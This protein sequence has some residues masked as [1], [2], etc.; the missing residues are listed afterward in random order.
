MQERVLFFARQAI[1]ICFLL[2][3]GFL[4]LLFNPGALFQGASAIIFPL[5]YELFEFNKMVG[6][7]ILTV[8]ILTFWL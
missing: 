2:L 4:P 3:F 6:V 5:N 8:A 7:Y 1:F